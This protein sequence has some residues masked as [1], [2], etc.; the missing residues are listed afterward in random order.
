ME[1][2]NYSLK[3]LLIFVFI[4]TVI[5]VIFYGIT[6]LITKN[7]DISSN[8]EKTEEAVIQYDE[9]VV[10]EIFSQNKDEYYVLAT[11]KDDSELSNYNSIITEYNEKKNSIKVYSINLNSG[12][13]KKY[14]SSSS[15]F[16]ND[17]PIFKESTLIK[18]SNK[19]IV[20]IYEGQTKIKEQLQIL[21]S[22]E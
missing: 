19:K 21:N 18:I 3:S 17:Y 9:I 1:T 5:I 7:K 11:F 2:N 22:L 10:G 4:I 6:T 16:D 14:I 13:N 8:N 12:F 15:K 20:D